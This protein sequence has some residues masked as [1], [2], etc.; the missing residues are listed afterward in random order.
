MAADRA[1]VRALLKEEAPFLRARG[2]DV[3]APDAPVRSASDR[4]VLWVGVGFLGRRALLGKRIARSPVGEGL[5]PQ[6]RPCTPKV[7]R[8]PLKSGHSV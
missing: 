8:L 5:A 7:G 4:E 2:I 1:L 6:R 3:T